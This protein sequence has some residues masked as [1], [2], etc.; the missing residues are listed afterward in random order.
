MTRLADQLE[1]AVG[2]VEPTFDL[3]DVHR[4]VRVRRARRATGRAVALIGVLGLAIGAIAIA[5]RPD[6][7][8][9]IRTVTTSAPPSEHALFE[10]A[11]GT[12]LL[13]DDGYDGITAIDLDRGVVTRRVIEGQRAGDQPYRLLRVG[14]SLIV[15]WG[16]IW[17]AP[18]S[19]APA[20]K[21]ADATIVLP[22]SEPGSVWVADYP[23]GCT[24]CGEPTFRRVR[25]DGSVVAEGHSTDRLAPPLIGIPGGLAR[26][27]SN[28]LDL[29]R[30]STGTTGHL[31][32]AP[33]FTHDV[34]GSRL[35]WCDSPCTSLHVTDLANNDDRESPIG[36]E[37]VS[38]R[39]SPDG[40]RL[41]VTSARRVTLVDAS[42][43]HGV[44]VFDDG[45]L[46]D[47]PQVGWSPDG[48]QLFV[49]GG[50]VLGR[51]DV[52]TG[53]AELV[54]LPLDV[55]GHVFVTATNEESTALRAGPRALP[56]DCTAPPVMRPRADTNACTFAL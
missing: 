46:G 30:P 4:R 54:A 14:N 34:R 15:G 31:G 5:T 3:D 40:T 48:S 6:S 27:S 1:R 26:Q 19:G 23:G 41:A 33:A 49:S 25:L 21:L 7:E 29:W 51:Y 47:R 18:L 42:S 45:R 20:H 13:F 24:G 12:T 11:T 8:K 53:H 55:G 35:A 37:V 52:R 50:S 2:V 28:G 22:A 43:G 10:E 56:T 44:I 9:K 32:N 38:A 39:F 16:E 36:G 17:A